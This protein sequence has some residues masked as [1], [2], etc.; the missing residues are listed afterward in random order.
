MSQNGKGKKNETLIKFNAPE[1]LK[2]DLQGLANDR[3][4]T[5]SSLLRLIASEY[6]KRSR[7]S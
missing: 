7:Q 6:V 4:I 3:N 1:V 2:N 5:L